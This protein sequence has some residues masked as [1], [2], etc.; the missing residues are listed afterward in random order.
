MSESDVDVAGTLKAAYG[1]DVPLKVTLSDDFDVPLGMQSKPG[2]VVVV[3]LPP[4]EVEVDECSLFVTLEGSD[5]EPKVERVYEHEYS[6]PS[7][8]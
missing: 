8:A 1:R 4:D 7:Q 3:R 6:I 2:D 5:G